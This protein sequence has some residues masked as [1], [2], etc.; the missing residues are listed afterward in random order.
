MLQKFYWMV[1]VDTCWSRSNP[2]DESELEKLII[3]LT[4]NCAV[5]G[6]LISSNFVKQFKHD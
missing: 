4:G 3:G 1:M 6:D 2:I 5:H